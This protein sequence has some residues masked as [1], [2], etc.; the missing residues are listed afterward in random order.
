MMFC[1]LFQ[2]ISNHPEDRRLENVAFTLDLAL[3]FFYRPLPPVFP[4]N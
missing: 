4:L 3:K 2:Y 1:Y